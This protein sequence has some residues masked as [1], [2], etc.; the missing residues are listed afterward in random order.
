[1]GRNHFFIELTKEDKEGAFDNLSRKLIPYIYE[2]VWK[3]IQ[4]KVSFTYWFC[5]C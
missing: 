3:W 2:S 4:V 1:M 5:E